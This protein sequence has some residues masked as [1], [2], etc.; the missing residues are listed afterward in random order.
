MKSTAIH[1][2]T[3]QIPP[4][5]HCSTY[6]ISLISRNSKLYSNYNFPVFKQK[7]EQLF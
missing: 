7:T 6:Y 5:L 4:A 1:I 2:T 3:G